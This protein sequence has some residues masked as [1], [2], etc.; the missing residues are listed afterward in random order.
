MGEPWACGCREVSDCPTTRGCT[1]PPAPDGQLQGVQRVSGMIYAFP[2][3]I[4]AAASDLLGVR[5]VR[6]PGRLVGSESWVS[7]ELPARGGA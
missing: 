1:P 4:C 2:A 3:S 5:A 7:A 6:R